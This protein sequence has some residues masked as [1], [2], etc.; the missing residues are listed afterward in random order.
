MVL[1]LL[2]IDFKGFLFSNPWVR[3]DPMATGQS[4]TYLGHLSY[5]SKKEYFL[6]NFSVFLHGKD[7]FEKNS[8]SMFISDKYQMSQIIYWPTI[9]L[10]GHNIKTQ[11]NSMFL[12]ISSY[13]IFSSVDE[14]TIY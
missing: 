9:N 4:K 7:N 12:M 5:L 11:K 14:V 13:L 2:L 1:T 8:S 10:E 6:M 3:D